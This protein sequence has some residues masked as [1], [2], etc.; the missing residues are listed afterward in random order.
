[1]TVLGFER[2]GLTYFAITSIISSAILSVGSYYNFLSQVR[3]ALSFIY[4][5]CLT[6]QAL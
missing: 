6:S 5:A 4:P 2:A 1:M 3:S